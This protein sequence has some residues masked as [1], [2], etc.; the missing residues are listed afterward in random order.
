M[1]TNLDAE[2]AA[3]HPMLPEERLTFTWM[4]KQLMRLPEIPLIAFIRIEGVASDVDM[5]PII[6]AIRDCLNPVCHDAFNDVVGQPEKVPVGRVIDLWRFLVREGGGRPTPPASDSS[7]T[8]STNGTASM[9]G[10]PST[11]EST[12]VRSEPAG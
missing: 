3:T 5:T 9:G 2:W 4:G 7:S 11:G 12:F 1:S 8:R 6:D 10:S